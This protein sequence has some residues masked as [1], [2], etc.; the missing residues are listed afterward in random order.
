VSGGSDGLAQT[1][2]LPR[3]QARDL[4]PGDTHYSAYVGPPAQY[5]FM[6][7][8]QFRLLAALGLRETHRV[9]DVGCGGLRAGRLLIPYLNEGCYCGIEPNAWLVED[10][11]A[12]EVGRDL[13]ARKAPAFAFRDDFDA[14]GFGKSFDFIVAQ[15]I[16]SHAGPGMLRMALGRLAPVL[17]ERGLML[18][19]FIEAEI[20][21]QFEVETEGWVYPECLTYR[22][23][24]LQDIVSDLG[25]AHQRL[26]WFHP[27]QTWF[28]LAKDAA[29]LVPS[30]QLRHLTGAVLRTPEFA[31]SRD[32]TP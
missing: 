18:V 17:A 13:I 12:N 3:R 4:R 23:Q 10:A 24:T 5:D 14:R 31:S 7:A 6:G 2:S 11:I 1:R 29:D 9:L 8:T 19:T 26:P 25:L 20:H 22:A 16:F 27:R 30:D 32:V 28:A 21:P 15:S